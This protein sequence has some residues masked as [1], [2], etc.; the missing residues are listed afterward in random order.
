MQKTDTQVERKSILLV[1]KKP[2]L[3][4]W[5]INFFT[6]KLS[7]NQELIHSAGTGWQ[8]KHSHA[9]LVRN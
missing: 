4:Q 5:N 9:I 3:K 1:I 2:T 6:P 8:D 7:T